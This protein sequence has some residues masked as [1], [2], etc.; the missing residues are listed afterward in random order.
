MGL[1]PRAVAGR[2]DRVP[3]FCEG[4]VSNAAMTK[5]ALKKGAVK[6]L[7][8]GWM[9]NISID[10]SQFMTCCHSRSAKSYDNFVKA[11]PN[12]ACLAFSLVSDR[13][14]VAGRAALT[15]QRVSLSDLAPFGQGLVSKAAPSLSRQQCPPRV[16]RVHIVI[17]LNQHISEKKSI[18]TAC[19]RMDGRHFNRRIAFNW[20]RGKSRQCCQISTKLSCLAF[21]I[22]F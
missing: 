13:K 22:G 9:P 10:T 4:P 2:E 17:D 1:V 11:R 7:V 15:R 14:R 16:L 20:R 8:G 19:E 21:F 12:F 6:L 3:L 5:N 18:Q